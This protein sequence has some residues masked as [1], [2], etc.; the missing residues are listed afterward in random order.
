MSDLY[1]QKTDLESCEDPSISVGRTRKEKPM[2]MYKTARYRVKPEKVTEV[3]QAMN[4]HAARLK[5]QFPGFLWWTVK[6]KEDPNLYLSL[7]ISPDENTNQQASGSEGT[8]IFVNVLYPNLIG[9][10]EW[11]DWQPVAH[12]TSIP[13]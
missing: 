7:I 8:G 2:K 4:E 12:T 10:V 1:G 5:E 9:E 3:E 13:D 6:A 11:T